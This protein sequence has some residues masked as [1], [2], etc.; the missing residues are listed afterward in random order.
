M[1][2]ALI[3][4]QS[5]SRNFAL[6]SCALFAGAA[7]YISLVE[8]PSIAEGGTNLA[9]TYLMFSQ[10]RPMI[11]QTCF[12]GI[13]GLAGILSGLTAFNPWWLAGG[14]IL[15]IAALTHIFVITPVARDLS[16]KVWSEKEI[17]PKLRS[18]SRHYGLQSIAG[19]AALFIYIMET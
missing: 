13:G 16:S 4:I 10:P 18:L 3:L 2:E 1:Q 7:T 17:Q 6:F 5:I 8:R 9:S 14:V 12:A 11:F 15:T 19:L